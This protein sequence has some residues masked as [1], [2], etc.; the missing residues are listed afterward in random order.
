[1]ATLNERAASLGGQPQ[2]SEA[3]GQNLTPEQLQ[4]VKEQI[5]VSAAGVLTSAGLVSLASHS[6]I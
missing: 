3:G 5:E 2:Q 1:M 6:F 4:Q